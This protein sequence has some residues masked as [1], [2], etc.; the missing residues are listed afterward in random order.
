M[1]QLQGLNFE[2][3][4]QISNNYSI[5]VYELSDI[6]T[7]L[8]ELTQILNVVTLVQILSNGV[9]GKDV[10]INYELAVKGDNFIEFIL[11]NTSSFQS[12]YLSIIKLAILRDRFSSYFQSNSDIHLQIINDLN[13]QQLI[14]NRVKEMQYKLNQK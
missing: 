10:F 13:K 8:T 14:F 11:N 12:K 2:K 4:E 3:V 6:K 5:D 1:G 7:T 9:S